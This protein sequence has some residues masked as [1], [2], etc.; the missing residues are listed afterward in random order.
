MAHDSA[1]ALQKKCEAIDA[2]N[3]IEFSLEEYRSDWGQWHGVEPIMDDVSLLT[4][5]HDCESARGF[6]PPGSYGGLRA[7]Q[8]G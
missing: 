2:M 8:F 5:I 6:D 7:A 4:R 3:R 1:P